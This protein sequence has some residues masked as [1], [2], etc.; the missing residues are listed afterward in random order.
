LIVREVH[1]LKFLWLIRKWLL[2]RREESN[3]FHL[4]ASISRHSARFIS[5]EFELELCHT[6]GIKIN[7]VTKV[8]YE[9]QRKLVADIFYKN[10]KLICNTTNI[11]KVLQLIADDLNV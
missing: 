5:G 1:I 6:V 3:P 2:F 4:D 10:N 8:S 7:S 9:I 11:N